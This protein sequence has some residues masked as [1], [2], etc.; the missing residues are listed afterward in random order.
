M[1]YYIIAGEASGDLHASNLMIALKS[2]DDQA[3]FYCWGG[4]KMQA[5]GGRLVEHYRNTAFMGFIEVVKNLKKIFR[6]IRTCKQSI[7]ET[8]P[9]VLILVDYPGFNLRIAQWAKSQHIKTVY[10]ITP[11]VWA[12]H[13]SRVHNLGKWTDLLLVILPFEQAFFEKF[14]YKAHY[15]GHPLT[16]AIHKYV[17]DVTFIE[18]YSNSQIIALL[19]GSRK[20]EIQSILPVMLEA[21]S[22]SDLQILLAGAPSIPDS[23]YLE[24]I[25]NMNMND[26]C[27]LVRDKT[28]DILSVARFALVG[29]GTAT[30]ETALF[31][32]PQIVCYK[33]STISY[34]IAKRLIKI[35]YISLVNLISGKE[36]VRELIQNDLNTENIRFE[37]GQLYK[38]EQ[39]IQ[40][41]YDDLK[42]KL[43]NAGASAKAAY[44][45]NQLVHNS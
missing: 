5:A 12:W 2:T 32:V 31:R 1:K 42:V 23:M 37:I 36:V 30:L 39:K 43:G 15:T 28:Y 13:Q 18:K 35:P 34:H 20:Q 6:Y 38:N 22:G 21:V 45:I 7:L 16:D 14:G 26:R 17:P 25:N 3:Q 29:S 33:A 19:P 10:F 24:I 40:Q 41:D 44:L 8:K 11:Q 9:D 4:D 27:I